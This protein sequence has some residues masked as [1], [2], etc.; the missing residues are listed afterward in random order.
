MFRIL[1]ARAG[2]VPSVPALRGGM[3]GCSTG[4]HSLLRYTVEQVYDS[5]NT[6]GNH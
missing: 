3:S 1:E 5:G 4:G 2:Y 6:C